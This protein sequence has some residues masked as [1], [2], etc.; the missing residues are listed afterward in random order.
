MDKH[1]SKTLDE[2]IGTTNQVIN[3]AKRLP[4]NSFKLQVQAFM[5]AET[6]INR[7]N[8]ILAGLRHHVETHEV[9]ILRVPTSD[10][11]ARIAQ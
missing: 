2:S 9:A 3:T 1:I 6:L 4:T 11:L 8:W 10:D 5:V 7:A